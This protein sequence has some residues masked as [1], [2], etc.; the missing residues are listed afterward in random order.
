MESTFE[1]SWRWFPQDCD[2]P[3]TIELKAVHGEVA[4]LPEYGLLSLGVR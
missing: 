1:V 3:H 4:V 2:V